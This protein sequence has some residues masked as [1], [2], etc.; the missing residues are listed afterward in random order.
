[1]HARIT[2]DANIISGMHKNLERRNISAG[3]AEARNVLSF[4]LVSRYMGSR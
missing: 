2:S 4:P 3:A 1:M